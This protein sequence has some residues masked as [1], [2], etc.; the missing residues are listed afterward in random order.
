VEEEMRAISMALALAMA[1]AVLVAGC[2]E[3]VELAYDS[4][5]TNVVVEVSSSG[6]LPTPWLDGAALFTL[7]GDGRVVKKSDETKH[8]LLLV[9]GRLDQDSLDELLRKIED[10]GFFEL[11]NDYRNRK[12]M[13]GVTSTI[14]VN[15]VDQKKVVSNYMADV[16]AFADTRRAIMEFPVDGLRVYIPDRGYLYVSRESRAPENPQVPPPDIASLVPGPEKLEE[17][18]AGRK[19]IELDGKPFV[20]LKKWESTQRYVG[21]DIQAGTTWYRVYPLYRPAS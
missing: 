6:G 2:S 5:P 9:E 11:E 4:A 3:N 8:V 7:Y 20:A 1:L 13:D 19:T 15:L 12:V 16:P 14:A 21:L 17:A 10:M 18:A